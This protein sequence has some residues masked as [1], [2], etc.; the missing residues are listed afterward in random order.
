M[1]LL[2]LDLLYADNSRFVI[3]RGS[4]GS[5]KSYAL[6]QRAIL[7]LMQSKVKWLVLRKVGKS[8]RESVFALVKSVISDMDF[9]EHFK[10]NK[11][12]MSIEF[13]NGSMIIMSGLDDVEKLKSIHGVD[14]IWIRAKACLS[15]SISSHSSLQ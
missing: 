14:K 7:S 12:D 3:L 6:A 11:T 5:G 8:L 10:I 2:Y 13:V 15:E 1:N 4:A 9:Y